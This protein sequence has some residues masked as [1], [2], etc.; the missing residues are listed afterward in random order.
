MQINKKI[1][2]ALIIAVLTM[3]TIMAAL[4]T[5]F[6][7]TGDPA[8]FATPNMGAPIAVIADGPVGTGVS[9][10]A[11]S[12]DGTAGA[13]A[14]YVEVS[15]YWDTP[16][17]AGFLASAYSDGD[18]YYRIDVVI[19]SAVE[20]THQLIV[21]DG[22]G[23]VDVPFDVTPLVTVS[24]T[25]TTKDNTYEAKVLPGDAL[26][27]TGHGFAGGI[28][29]SAITITLENSTDVLTITTPSVKTNSTGSFSAVISIPT[30]AVDWYGNW[31]VRATDASTN[32]ATALILIDYYNTVTP[33]Q[34]PSGITVTISGRIPAN[35]PY[36][37]LID[38][39]NIGSGTSG[40]DGVFTNTYTI[41]TLIAQTGHTITVR[42]VVATVVNTRD[43][44]FTVVAPP[45]ISYISA[46][47]GVSGAVIT[48]SGT[49]FTKGA[50]ITLTLG[51]TVV[52]ST[53]LD[54]RFGPT[55]VVTGGF[56]NEQFTV[57]AITSG[58][59]VLTVTDEYGAATDGTTTFTVLPTPTTTIALRGTSYYTGDTLSFNIVTTETTSTPLGTITVNIYDPSG[60]AQWTI[61]GWN[62][63]GVTTKIVPIMSQVTD[64]PT[65]NP[66][67]LPADAPLGT[68][69]WTIIYTPV[70]TGLATKATAL[71]TVAAVPTL[72]A[73]LDAI[74]SM[75]ASITN[76]ITTTEG[77]I[78]AVINTKAGQIVADIADLDAKLVSIDAGM[79]TLETKLGT[80]E[81]AVSNLNI[82]TL[83][84][85]VTA[86]KGDVATIKTNIGT[87]N[88][89]VSNLDAKV[90]SLA[91]DVATVK[92]NVGTLQGTVT[93]IDGK[94]ATIDT[95]VGSLQADVSDVAAKADVTPVWI[96]VVLS[97]VAAIAAIFAVITIR[98]K[99]AG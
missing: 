40:S 48:I 50:K 13:A 4:P 63:A 95:G 93:S 85:D 7:L 14:A 26:T 43:T 19:P 79:A 70:S 17:P 56:T 10:I 86:I 55:S 71:F 28:L 66:L 47:S 34:G 20:G 25:P 1:Y 60:R 24:T 32:T 54:S 8:L 52:N 96:A 46:T 45:V 31:D 12:T 59:Y 21:N 58:V 97:L 99:I 16:T 98:Q 92:T 42:W 22:N 82:G 83:G 89:A 11:N 33:T 15:A 2:T 69:N 27:V 67:T 53:D 78:I 5:A 76:V 80:V 51:S 35:M 73:V 44:T 72:D 88:T 39:T 84:A 64:S 61:T 74:D 38:T 87:V 49:G 75:E 94:V 81:T 91:G 18:G 57:P 68:W 3:S 23:A 65:Y 37:I 62:P 29:G 77:D 90:V 41:P 6:A 9:I 36:T 30:I